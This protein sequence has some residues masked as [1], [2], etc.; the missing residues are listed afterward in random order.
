M[1]QFALCLAEKEG[2]VISYEKEC[3]EFKRIA[4]VCYD[5]VLLGRN[6]AQYFK[7]QL[8]LSSEVMVSTSLFDAR[9]DAKRASML[10]RQVCAAN[11]DMIFSLDKKISGFLKTFRK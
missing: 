10:A 4:F 3:S 11:F 8:G 7:E 2:W 5:A 1:K 9:G 6:V